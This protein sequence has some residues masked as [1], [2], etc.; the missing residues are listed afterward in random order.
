[1]RSL[2]REGDKVW[3]GSITGHI[4][5][6]TDNTATG[7]GRTIAFDESRNFYKRGDYTWFWYDK[8]GRAGGNDPD[9][10]TVLTRCGELL[11]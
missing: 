7:V 1:M 8:S 10:Y 4:I 3:F 9:N 11:R 6:P 5:V 2:W